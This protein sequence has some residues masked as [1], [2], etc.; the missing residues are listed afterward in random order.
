[1]NRIRKTQERSR[2]FFSSG[3]L[4]AKKKLRESRRKSGRS[5]DTAQHK[6]GFDARVKVD[7][8]KNPIVEYRYFKRPPGR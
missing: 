4:E 3:M 2:K 8:L 6:K 1:M 7:L 5:G